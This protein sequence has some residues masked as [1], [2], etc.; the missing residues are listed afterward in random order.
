MTLFAGWLIGVGSTVLVWAVC[1]YLDA[2]RFR[3]DLLRERGAHPL[4]IRTARERTAIRPLRPV[5]H[6]FDRED[7]LN[8]D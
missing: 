3:R 2:R 8:G 1:S 4:D 6:D 7:T 5:E